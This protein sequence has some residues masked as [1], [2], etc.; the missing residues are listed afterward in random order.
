MLKARVS[1][2]DEDIEGDNG[3]SNRYQMLKNAE[4]ESTQDA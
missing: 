1:D 2:G 3:L 4:N